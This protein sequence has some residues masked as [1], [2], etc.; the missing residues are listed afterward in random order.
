MTDFQTL[1]Q[2]YIATWNETDAAARAEAVAALYAEDAR[3]TD[4]LVD[5]EGREAITA[6]IGA[7]QQQFPG[8]VFRLA[9]PVDAHHDQARFSWELGPAGDPDAPIAGFD[10]AVRDEAGRLTT[11]FGFLD[12]VPSAG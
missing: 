3:Y 6:T 5:A 8:F 4:P 9:G 1:A 11:V 7:V 12:R 2:R 10:V